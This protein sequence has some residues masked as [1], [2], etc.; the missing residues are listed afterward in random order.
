MV[1][2]CL[3]VEAAMEAAAELTNEARCLPVGVIVE[4]L[5]GPSRFW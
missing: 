1:D 4:R 2:R 5:G 3:E